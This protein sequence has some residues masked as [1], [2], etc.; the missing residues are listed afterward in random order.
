MWSIINC[1]ISLQYCTVSALINHLHITPTTGKTLF[2]H[3]LYSSLSTGLA[4]E[5]TKSHTAYFKG[6]E[7]QCLLA[8]VTCTEEH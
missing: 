6:Y 1:Y 2:I 8:N 4:C 7:A 3:T 5:V